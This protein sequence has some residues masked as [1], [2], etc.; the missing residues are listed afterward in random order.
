MTRTSSHT[1]WP[2]RWQPVGQQRGLIQGEL[3]ILELVSMHNLI[4]NK[5]FL[6]MEH[7]T[8]RYTERVKLLCEHL[9]VKLH[10]GIKEIGDLDV[11]HLL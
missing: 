6:R 1:S 11:S 7:I 5:I 8:D 2:P 3:G 4:P 9:V 10:N